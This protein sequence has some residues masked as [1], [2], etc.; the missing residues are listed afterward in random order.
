[1]KNK[2]KSQNTYSKRE[3]IKLIEKIDAEDHQ[4]QMQAEANKKKGNPKRT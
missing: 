2:Q 1:M 3:L 4:S